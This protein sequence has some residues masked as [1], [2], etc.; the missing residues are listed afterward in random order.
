MHV[1]E[2]QRDHVQEEGP[3]EP[4]S[5]KNASLDDH[6]TLMLYSWICDARGR[7]DDDAGAKNRAQQSEGVQHDELH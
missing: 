4:E 5:L 7:R 6:G 1:R 2:P 3:Q